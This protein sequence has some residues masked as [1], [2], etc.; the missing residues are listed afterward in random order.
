M[1]DPL[2]IDQLGNPRLWDTVELRQY[3]IHILHSSNF[4]PLPLYYCGHAISKAVY[5]SSLALLLPVLVNFDPP[6]LNQK[7]PFPYNEK[8]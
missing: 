1:A 4:Y 3:L 2:E 8:Y 6:P 5:I 7:G